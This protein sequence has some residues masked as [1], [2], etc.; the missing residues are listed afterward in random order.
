MLRCSVLMTRMS[1][2]S[3]VSVN[4]TEAMT[5]VNNSARSVCSGTQIYTPIVIDKRV[6]HLLA[7]LNREGRSL[8]VLALSLRT[9]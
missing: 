6:L 4:L 9:V 7:T 8:R 2:V 3:G 5:A 1:R